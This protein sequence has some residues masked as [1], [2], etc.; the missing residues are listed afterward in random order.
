MKRW[1]LLLLIAIVP[2]VVFVHTW[3]VFKYKQLENE[4]ERLQEEEKELVEQNKR[5]I[6]GIAVLRSPRR[7]EKIAQEEL[8][9][10]KLEAGRLI[11]VLLAAKER[12]REESGGGLDD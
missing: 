12:P 2:T 10:S 9:L 8:G 3:Q 4:I 5:L 7:L 11:R 6:A 1:Y